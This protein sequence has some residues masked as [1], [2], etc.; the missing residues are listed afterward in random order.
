MRRPSSLRRTSI[1]FSNF[2]PY[3]HTAT[4]GFYR[5]GKFIRR[6]P[7]ATALGLFLATAMTAGLIGSAI[8]LSRA[9]RERDRAETSFQIARSAVDE[10]FT[11]IDEQHEFEALGLQPVRATLLENLLRY[12]ENILDLRGN[13][14]GA[15]DLAAEAQHRHRPDRSPD[16]S[17]GRRCMATGKDHRPVRG[18]DRP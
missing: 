10:L 13:D 18:V 17:S 6:H 11:R 7:L 4:A 3:G 5:T 8:G 1:I 12:Y 2:A 15:R 16:R 14:P 9:R